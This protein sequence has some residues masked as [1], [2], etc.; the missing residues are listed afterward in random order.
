MTW[1]R[2]VTGI[3]V[4]CLC[5][6][7]IAPLAEGSP[8][9]DLRVQIDIEPLQ[10]RE[11]SEVVVLRPTARPLPPL[12]DELLEQK[13]IRL[14]FCVEPSGHV[15]EVSP[16]L[17]PNAPRQ[18]AGALGRIADTVKQWAFTPIPTR[19]CFQMRWTFAPGTNPGDTRTP[20]T[21]PRTLARDLDPL[22]IV[23]RIDP[24]LPDNVAAALKGKGDTVFS[25]KLCVNREGR[26][27]RIDIL[28]S[29]PG[30]DETIVK[31][32]RQWRYKPQ[33]IELCFPSRW[34]FTVY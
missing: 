11:P 9:Q 33:P 1:G 15:S 27:S 25:A 34:V 30:G 22:Q 12:G 7:T 18:T 4:L 3:T 16:Q 29:I 14:S 26:I 13:E 21:E 23:Y 2:W 10:N 5:L 32:I 17:E 31:A 24:H 8:W 28:Q 19:G 20:L 6:C